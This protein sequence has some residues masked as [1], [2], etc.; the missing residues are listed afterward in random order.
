MNMELKLK[1]IKDNRYYMKDEFM[2]VLHIYP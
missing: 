1:Y 2:D